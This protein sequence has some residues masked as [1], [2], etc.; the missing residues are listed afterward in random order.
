[1]STSKRALRIAL[2][3][4]PNTGKSSV[5]NRL[6]GLNQKVSNYPGITV[7]KRSGLAKLADHALAEVIDLP[8]TYSLHPNGQDERVVY[9]ALVNP[10]EA[11]RP[12]V[13]IGIADGTNLKR[14]LYLFT[15]VFTYLL[16]AIAY[17]LCIYVYACISIE[18][19]DVFIYWFISLLYIFV[20]Y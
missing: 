2:V 1:M 18:F 9:E 8:G 17:Y 3:G 16:F 11:D 14:H 4:N 15:Q 19:V 6:T 7:D 12:D 20:I 13:V 10:S 5:F